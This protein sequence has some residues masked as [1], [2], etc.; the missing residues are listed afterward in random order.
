MALVERMDLDRPEEEFDVDCGLEAVS[1]IP[2]G[3][4]CFRRPNRRGDSLLPLDP[5]ESDVPGRPGR[6]KE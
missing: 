5:F 2:A 3:W 4:G 6:L 1:S